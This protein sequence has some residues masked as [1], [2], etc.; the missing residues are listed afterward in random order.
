MQDEGRYGTSEPDAPPAA[1]AGPVVL[2]GKLVDELV[3]AAAA[4]PSMH[5]S[6]PWRFRAQPAA[7][8][9]ELRADPRAMLP[10]ADPHARALHIGCGAALFNLRA[11]AAVAGLEAQV[12]LLPHPDCEPLLLAVVR[13]A[14]PHRATAAERELAAAIPRRQTNRG[15]YRNRPVPP[16]VRAELAE[17]ARAEGAVL[18]F[19][20]EEESARLLRLAADAEQELLADPGYRAE[21]ARWAGGARSAEGIPDAA[22]GPRSPAGATPVRDFTPD[23]PPAPGQYAW[24][25]DHPQLSV[26][27]VGSADRVGWLRAGQALQ[28]V[29]LTATLRGISACPLTQALETPDAWQV[30]DPRAGME[31]PQMILRIGYGLPQPPG[32]PRRRAA[33]LIDSP[34]PGPGPGPRR[35]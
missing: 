5:N 16:G 4:A 7:A 17:A 8:A 24:F 28:R 27:S 26:L 13:L 32:A 30:R 19:P 12:R 31:H 3:A 22:L 33:D 6:Q 20:G 10:V 25:E 15:P 1:H 11:A 34:G 9:I 35:R 18:H 23:R 14:G 2:T 29:L 21:L